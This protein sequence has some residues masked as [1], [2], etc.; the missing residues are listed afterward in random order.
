MYQAV[1]VDSASA[2][3]AVEERSL[4]FFFKNPG[5]QPDFLLSCWRQ[6]FALR[7]KLKYEKTKKSNVLF[8]LQEEPRF[9]QNFKG[10]QAKF[11]NVHKE[12]LLR[13]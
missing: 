12:I 9:L 4:V 3:G 7:L 5:I 8:A 6:K 13:K 1:E 11:E 10:T 2:A